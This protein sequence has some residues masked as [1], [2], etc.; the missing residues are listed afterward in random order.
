MMM[1]ASKMT[2]SKDDDSSAAFVPFKLPFLHL[3][4][5]EQQLDFLLLAWA[6]LLH[7]RS[8]DL[9]ESES[10][11]GDPE[12]AFTYGSNGHPSPILP[13][14]VPLSDAISGD[15]DP[16]SK[17]LEAIRTI[18][19]RRSAR[20]RGQSASGDDGQGMFFAT[21]GLASEHTPRVC[22]HLHEPQLALILS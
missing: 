18:R 15:D 19:Q 17:T 3:R 12:P 4:D 14:A 9:I 6:L 22:C 5:R 13:A 11:S 7:R 8:V 2:A 16:V 10:G 1:T 20:N 21:A